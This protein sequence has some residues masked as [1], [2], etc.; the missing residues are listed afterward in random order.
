MVQ[1]LAERTRAAALLGGYVWRRAEAEGSARGEEAA[2]ALDV[3]RSQHFDAVVAHVLA[4]RGALQW[5][6]ESQ[7]YAVHER[8]TCRLA[9][10]LAAALRAQAAQLSTGPLP[11]AAGLVDDVAGEAARLETRARESMGLVYG[12]MRCDDLWQ[13]SW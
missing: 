9:E 12:G 8:G 1:A 2:A 10:R 7:C 3:L 4:C 13:S 6:A 11:A 5:A